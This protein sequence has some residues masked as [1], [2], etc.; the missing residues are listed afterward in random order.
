[1]GRPR[2]GARR[3]VSRRQ[4]RVIAGRRPR[5]TPRESLRTPDHMC[6]LLE[7][8]PPQPSPRPCAGVVVRSRRRLPL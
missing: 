8:L 3:R 2:R 6:L 7:T 1:M 5:R 4:P